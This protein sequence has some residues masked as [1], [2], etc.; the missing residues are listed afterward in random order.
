M[1]LL[2]ANG[3]FSKVFYQPSPHF[4]HRLDVNDISLVVIHNISLPAG[5]FGQTH[6]CDLFCHR[7]D[8]TAHPSFVS[9]RGL[10]VSA[11]FLISRQGAVTQ[12]V[13]C[14]HRA[15]H[16]GASH[17]EG[18]DNCNDYSIGIELEGTDDL[19]YNTIQYQVLSQIIH[20]LRDRWSAITRQRIVGHQHIAPQR[21]T[22][23]G[24][25]FDWAYLGQLLNF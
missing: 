10:K 20:V 15:W 6:V 8:Y 16:A 12:F 11:H 4:N 17:F 14:H 9:L 13:S 24:A 18:R 5:Q 22:D 23:P 2:Q 3:W 1:V 21:K 7:L 19:A 25:A